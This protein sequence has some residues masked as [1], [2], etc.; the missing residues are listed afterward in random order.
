MRHE[1]KVADMSFCCQKC[2]LVGDL[3]GTRTL[4]IG[5]LKSPIEDMES[6]MQS[7]YS[8]THECIGPTEHRIKPGQY[9]NPF[10]A[11]EIPLPC[12]NDMEGYC[13]DSEG[14]LQDC[15]SCVYRLSKLDDHWTCRKNYYFY[16]ELELSDPS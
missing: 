5:Y 9:S 14:I 1:L 10:M 8:A 7:S 6:H 16:T 2:G 15:G 13:R 3:V 12:C 11:I 4:F